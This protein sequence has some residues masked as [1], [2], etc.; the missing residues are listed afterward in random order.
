[1]ISINFLSSDF[2]KN[3]DFLDSHLRIDASFDIVGRNILTGDKK[4]KLYF[5][6]GFI[7]DDIMERIMQFLMSAD[8]K[9]VKKLTSTR[10]FANKYIP[11]APIPA[12]L[13][14]EPTLAQLQEA[15]IA[16]VAYGNFLNAVLNFII[17]SFVIFCIIKVINVISEKAKKKEAEEAPAA[18]ATKVCPYCKS[19]IAVDA[20]KCPNCTSELK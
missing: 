11:L 9:S 13:G 2:D 10:D 15:G 5:I 14:T 8:C 6:D 4:A 12:E 18:P 3:I 7:K 19:E 20:T 1:M 16:A 17:M